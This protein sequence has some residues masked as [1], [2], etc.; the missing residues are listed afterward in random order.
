MGI[1]GR[2]GGEFRPRGEGGVRPQ[3]SGGRRP[4]TMVGRPHAGSLRTGTPTPYATTPR[5]VPLGKFGS[6]GMMGADDG[7]EPPHRDA[8][9]INPPPPSPLGGGPLE[10]NGLRLGHAFLQGG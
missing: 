1:I 10:K 5:E 4:P 3:W 9:I 7:R 8:T 6:P 2:Y